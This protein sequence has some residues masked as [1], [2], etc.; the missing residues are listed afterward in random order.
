MKAEKVLGIVACAIVCASSS[1][2][3]NTTTNWFGVTA[4][5]TIE[6]TD[7]TIKTND[8]IVANIGDIVSGSEITLDGDTTLTFT[9]IVTDPARSDNLV[10]IESSAVLTPNAVSDLPPEGELNNAQ[11]GFAVAYEGDVTNYYC[12]AN[13]AWGAGAG[14]P[15]DPTQSITFKI[16]LDYRTNKAKFEVG[17]VVVSNDV[18]FAGSRLNSVAALGSGSLTKVDADYEIAVA[19][20]VTDGGATTNRYGSVADAN[21]AKTAAGAGAT[22]QGVS[23]TGETQTAG[24]TAANG[25]DYVVCEAMGLD[26]DSDTATIA[27]EPATTKAHADAITLA[28]KKPDTAEDGVNIVFQVKKNGAD[29]GAPCAWDDIQI[30]MATGT[31]TVVPSIQ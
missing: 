13:G 23:P 27:L 28:W 18:T 11:V 16:T 30:P 19:A 7:V 21:I 20:V 10:T 1:V 15:A 6:A 9:P 5:P 4:S 3:A 8:V 24:A 26:M 2:F 22:V 25:M 29:E 31:Y 17:N 12:Y 14:T